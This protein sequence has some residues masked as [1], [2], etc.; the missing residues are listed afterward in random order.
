[1][2]TRIKEEADLKKFIKYVSKKRWNSYWHQ[3]DEIIA[4]TPHSSYESSILEIGVGYNV[5]KTIC[6]DLLHYNYETLDI[7]GEF[8]PDHIGSVLEMP[9]ADNK[10]DTVVCFQMLE[11]LPYE[12]FNKALSEIFRVAKASVIISLPNTGL[13]IPLHI[14]IIFEKKFIKLPIDISSKKKLKTK[15]HQWEINFKNYKLKDVMKSILKTG[16]S[17][18]FKLTKNYRVWENPYHHFFVLIKTK[19]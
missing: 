18:N 15:S 10:Y 8:Y 3:I 14:P 16:E 17:Y 2:E 1:M 7:N 9:F 5:L 13:I 12:D 11:H 4:N 6:K 19:K